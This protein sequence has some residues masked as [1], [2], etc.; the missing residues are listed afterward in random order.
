MRT[1]FGNPGRWDAM[2]AQIAT[3]NADGFRAYVQL[4][5]ADR[6]LGELPETVT[7]AAKSGPAAA[8]VLFIA[9]DVALNTEGFAVIAIDL[10]GPG[11]PFRV[12]AAALWAVENNLNLA[13][14]SWED[15][16]DDLDDDGVFRSA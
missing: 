10:V 5:D 16:E 8:A 12:S 4:V 1:G 3:E 9:D 7:A 15:F 14:L 11:T 6:W 13:N 2:C